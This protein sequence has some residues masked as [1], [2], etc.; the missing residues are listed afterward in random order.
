MRYKR[1]DFPFLLSHL[2]AFPRTSLS[3]W[4]GTG[5]CETLSISE[6]L[7]MVSTLEETQ[8]GND[9]SREL[10][11]YDEKVHMF[12]RTLAEMKFLRSPPNFLLRPLRSRSTIAQQLLQTQPQ[13]MSV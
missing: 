9:A 10:R 13:L 6:A 3:R 1:E 7:N 2:L 4:E 11:Q 12:Q 5:K 8:R